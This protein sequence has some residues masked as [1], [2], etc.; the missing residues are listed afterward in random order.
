MTVA[1]DAMGIGLILPVTPD[2]IR[3]LRG[4]GISDAALWGGFLAFT[5]AAMQFLCGPLLGNLSDRFG[6]RPVLIVSLTAMG[7]S[8]LMMALAPTL[9]LLFVARFIAGISG[10]THATAAAYLADISDKGKRSANFGLIGAAFGVGFILGPAIGG[11]LGELG[12]RAPFIAAGV[13]A[14]AN[15]LFGYLTL[16]ETLT[17]ENRRTFDLRRANPFKAL[18]RARKLPV[19][20]PLLVVNFLYVIS[21]FVYPV[22][23]SYFTIE[24]FGWSTGTVGLSLA[25]FGLCSAF[26]QGWLI[27]KLLVWLGEMR[28]A[29]FGFSM[30]I[31][32]VLILTFIQDGFMVFLFMPITA[33]GVVVGPALQGMMADRLPDNEQGELQGVLASVNGIAVIVSPLLMTGVFRI[34]TAEETPV[35]LPGAPFLAAGLLAAVAL[36]LLLQGA[37]RPATA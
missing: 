17:E 33:L 1:L 32:A 31:V 5:F 29:I 22:I 30:H 10:A 8:N 18:A 12:P 35:Y 6:R 15:A 27:R 7:L 20:G 25:A 37:R 23:W 28:T 26:V 4:E 36:W 24:R 2:L 11:L 9:L 34:F 19:V 21:N 3:E 13:L 14:L 16:P